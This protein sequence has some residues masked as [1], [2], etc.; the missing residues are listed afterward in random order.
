MNRRVVG[1]L[2]IVEPQPHVR[3]A[4]GDPFDVRE[5]RIRRRAHGLEKNRVP[6]HVVPSDTAVLFN[7]LKNAKDLPR[8][9][10]RRFQ[11]L[12]ASRHR[13]HRAPPGRPGPDR[14]SPGG[15][16]RFGEGQRTRRARGWR[17]QAKHL[18]RRSR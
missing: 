9:A 4:V 7:S 17:R 15:S 6:F 11:R 1:V 10:P 3:N 14:P 8:H 18:P 12:H 5:L 13:H 16:I 2:T